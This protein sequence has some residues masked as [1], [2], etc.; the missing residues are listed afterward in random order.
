M[1]GLN[2]RGICRSY[3]SDDGV[4][5]VIHPVVDGYGQFLRHG[6]SYV[7]LYVK[8]AISRVSMSIGLLHG[9][10]PNSALRGR[11]SPHGKCTVV[12]G[13]KAEEAGVR[14]TLVGMMAFR[15]KKE[16]TLCGPGVFFRGLAAQPLEAL[17]VDELFRLLLSLSAF[18][19]SPSQ[20]VEV[21][22]DDGDACRSRLNAAANH[23]PAFARGFADFPPCKRHLMLPMRQRF[24]E[25]VSGILLP[26][27]IAEGAA[28]CSPLIVAVA[29]DQVI[30]SRVARSA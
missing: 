16:R 24:G 30:I 17:P 9:Q 8:D 12:G 18:G 3:L 13:L 7:C 26:A 23:L 27:E 4:K 29:F 2:P 22:V 6:H 5:A 14:S 11:A 15:Q 21:V 19:F 28:A 25:R 20:Q 1:V 10:S